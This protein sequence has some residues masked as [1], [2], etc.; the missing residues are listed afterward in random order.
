MTER[1][2]PTSNAISGKAAW[3]VDAALHKLRRV[4]S[5][6]KYVVARFMRHAGL[7]AA[8]ALAYTSLL[9]LVPLLAIGLALLAAFPQF[10]DARDRLQEWV[11]TNFV[12]T[13]GEQVQGWVTQ[14]IGNAGQLTAVGVV[15]LAF[16]AIMLLLTI[17]SAINV[18][19]RVEQERR[20]SARLFVY[21][22]IMTLGPLLIGASFSLAGTLNA[23]GAYAEEK[24]IA[25]FE[26]WASVLPTLLVVIAFS[27]LYFAVPNRPVRMRDALAGGLAAGLLFTF[28]RWSFGIYIGSGRTY[29]TLY[30]AMAVLP[31]FLAWMY[32][33]WVV[34][35]VGAEITAALPEWRQGRL[36]QTGPLP[37][38]RRLALAL[39]VL[40]ALYEDS[41]AGSRGLSRKRLLAATA[42]GGEDLRAVL[43]LLVKTRLIAR[44]DDGR[45]ILSRDPGSMTLYQLVQALDLRLAPEPGEVPKEDWRQALLERLAQADQGEHRCLDVTLR[46][47]FE[48]GEVAEDRPAAPEAVRRTR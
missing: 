25:D 14:F 24:G 13:V 35:L 43:R 12:P 41:R 3:I 48:P 23:I 37:A 9:A 39:D 10:N 16:T 2:H 26:R 28:L 1:R 5:F 20:L 34:V 32:F 46:A 19:F 31:I 44:F 40:H 36:E 30:G 15:G 33:S 47:L 4:W 27:I 45:Y 38:S 7:S 18:I 11:F 42:A 6:P 29:E 21:W 22:T 8:S 17:E